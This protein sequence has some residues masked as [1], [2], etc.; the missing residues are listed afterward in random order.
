M[1]RNWRSWMAVTC[2]LGNVSSCIR[3]CFTGAAAQSNYV[4]RL[5]TNVLF[6][7]LHF[8]EKALQDATKVEVSTLIGVTFNG[9]AP[10]RLLRV[11]LTIRVGSYRVLMSVFCIIS[12]LLM[13]KW[14]S[15]N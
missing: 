7:I 4:F 11:C 3:R 9:R 2:R 8:A 12:A 15:A 1:A 6:S 13:K 10:F 5:I 14:T